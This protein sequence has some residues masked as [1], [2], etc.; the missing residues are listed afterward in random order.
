MTSTLKMKRSFVYILGNYMIMIDWYFQH[1][2]LHKYVEGVTLAIHKFMQ[3]GCGYIA[4][5]IDKVMHNCIV[6]CK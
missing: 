5:I 2:I 3:Q 6:N 1:G 4:S